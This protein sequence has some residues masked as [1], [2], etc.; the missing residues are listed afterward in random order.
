MPFLT[1]IPVSFKA[2]DALQPL[3]VSLFSPLATEYTKQLTAH[4]HNSQGLAG[5]KKR[6][7]FRLFY[8]SWTRTFTERHILRSFE[9]AGLWP[10]NAAAI[11]DRFLNKRPQV[12]RT[13]STIEA[14]RLETRG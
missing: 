5:V 7:F 6:D 2:S 13:P 9:V 1:I 14:K 10:P 12:P 11:V 4:L 3:D 8:E